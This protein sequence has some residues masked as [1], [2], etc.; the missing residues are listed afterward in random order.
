[1]HTFAFFMPTRWLWV[2][3][4]VSTLEA[5]SDISSE[6]LV[7]KV[8]LNV[9]S[10]WLGRLTLLSHMQP[11]WIIAGKSADAYLKAVHPVNSLMTKP[12]SP[13]YIP[14]QTAVT[15]YKPVLS[16]STSISPCV[17]FIMNPVGVKSLLGVFMLSGTLTRRELRP[18]SDCRP[19]FQ[20]R[21][22]RQRTTEGR[23]AN[24]VS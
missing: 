24:Q 6:G 1:M 23:R 11:L 16:P 9:C 2:F 18:H 20:W 14:T 12:Q 19:S 4:T 22:S 3:W 8:C 15:E 5:H 21:R 13:I 7:G 10:N 17:L